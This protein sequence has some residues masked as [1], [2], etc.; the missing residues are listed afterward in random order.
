[1]AIVNYPAELEQY[2]LVEGFRATVPDERLYSPTQRGPGLVQ[3]SQAVAGGTPIAA[4]TVIS[5]D[6]VMRYRRW[7]RDTI[8]KGT[9]PFRIRN[10]Q[11]DGVSLS[12]EDD[13]ALV[14]YTEE[15]YAGTHYWLV[16]FDPRVPPPAETVFGL[17]WRLDFAWIRLA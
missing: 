5:I 16:M 3:G 14:D 15:A 9:K 1:M 12:N 8:L 2:L 17:E 13:T 6:D 11:I 4:S 7:W 10:Q